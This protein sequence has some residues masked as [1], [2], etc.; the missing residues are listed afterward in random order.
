MKWLLLLFPITCLA[1]FNELDSNQ[2]YHY[3]AKT[4]QAP[5]KPIVKSSSSSEMKR[6]AKKL[7]AQ[8]QKL[9]ELLERQ[10]RKLIVR[11]KVDK[12]T[13]LSRL[14][15]LVLNSI[16]ATNSKPAT[17]IVR[18]EKSADY[19]AGAELRCLGQSYDKRILSKCD[20]LVLDEQEYAVDIALWDIDGAEGII[21]DYTYSGA[22]KSFLTSSFASFMQGVL[23]TA[24]DRISTPFGEVTRS[25]GKNKVLGGLMGV[26]DNTRE[27]VA[28]SGEENLS[29]SYLNSGK[30]VLVFFNQSLILSP[31]EEQ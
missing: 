21:A 12:I 3:A 25:N 2:L 5:V 11:T 23:D 4:K 24:R 19:L 14:P 16:L 26:A 7:L 8:D 10:D 30:P 20:L 9:S 31:K 29:V 13:A 6:I 1:G 17:F 15:G 22:E 28:R 18:L 27:R